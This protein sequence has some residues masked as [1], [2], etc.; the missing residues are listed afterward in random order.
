MKLLRI[1]MS[2][3]DE[4]NGKVFTKMTDREWELYST[5]LKFV[6]YPIEISV[7]TNQYI[8]IDNEQDILDRIEVK[9]ISE[10]TYFLLLGL[11][12]FERHWPYMIDSV[13]ENMDDEHEA[14][15][16]E[17]YGNEEDDEE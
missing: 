8:D 15:W 7:G 2:W 12:I 9:D 1:D 14:I 16:N 11:G 17:F 10:E 5:A 13:F 6:N 3:A 4:T